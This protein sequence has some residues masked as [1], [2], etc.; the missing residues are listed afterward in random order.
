MDR[1]VAEY[2]RQIRKMRSRK[3]QA[4]LCE[5]FEAASGRV[6]CRHGGEPKQCPQ[7][8]LVLQRD[9]SARLV[10]FDEIDEMLAEAGAVEALKRLRRALEPALGRL[11]VLAALAGQHQQHAKR[12]L[13]I[14][15]QCCEARH[16]GDAPGIVFRLEQRQGVRRVLGFVCQQGLDATAELAAL[17]VAFGALDRHLIQQSLDRTPQLAAEAASRHVAFERAQNGLVGRI[18]RTGEA[19]AGGRLHERDRVCIGERQFCTQQ[20][21][22]DPAQSAAFHSAPALRAPGAIGRD[23]H[24]HAVCRWERQDPTP[25]FGVA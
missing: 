16:D 11:G 14:S 6:G 4:L 22:H 21:G 8:L 12:A 17:G 20:V 18:A 19:F 7:R 13:Q 2:K 9:R 5:C 25:R 24:P 3:G 23:H 15:R 1:R 10:A